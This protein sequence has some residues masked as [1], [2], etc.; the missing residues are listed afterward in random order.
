M[1]PKLAAILLFISAS[2]F[3]GW[4]DPSGRNERNLSK[5]DLEKGF[6]NPPPQAR[7]FT[8]WIWMNGNV[9]REGITADLEAM[10]RVGIGGVLL[11]NVAGSHGTDIPAGPIDYL[12][13]AWL[14]LV[15]HTASEA[16]RLGMEMG[17]H[18]CAGWATTGGPWIKPEYG[19]QQMVTAE[20]SL[21]G[22]RRVVQ[23]LPHPEVFEGYYN[24]IA[25]YAFPRNMDIGYRVHQWEPKT[26]QR[27]G[28]AGR[29]PDLSPVP[30][31]S[32]I[33]AD[34]ILE[35]SQYVNEEGVLE[36]DAPPGSW[37]IL[38]MGYTAK[39]NTNHPAAE[40]GRGLEIDK[41]RRET[42]DLH[43]REGIQPVLDHLG[44]LVGKSFHIIH[45]DS[46]EAGL[47]HWTPGMK[48]EF[49]K[50][51]GYDPTPYLLA[52]TGRL[53]EDPETTERFLWDF[54]ITISDL[55]TENYYGYLA[56]L[57]HKS[58]LH[59]LTEPYTS[60]YEG[61]R[62]AAK[63]DY[64]TAE[65][66]VNGGY[67][68]SLRH[69]ASLAHIHGRRYA[70][71]EAFT[72]APHLARW[73]NHPGSIKKVGDWAWTQ[74]IN[75]FVLHSYP[76]QP[77]I[78]VV[79]GM[80]MGQYGCHFDRNNTW[81]E[82]GRAW[83]KYLQRSQYLLQEGE[84]VADILCYAGDAAP[85]GGVI[86]PDI[87]DSGYDYDACGTD[88][89]AELKVDHGD[90]VLPSGKR[91]RLLVLPETEFMRPRFA[92][93]V[94]ELV[95]AGA[96]VLGPKP[97]YTP[98]L[99]GFPESEE[100]VMAIGE[101]VWG[102]CDGSNVTSNRFGKGQVFSGI[103]PAG[104]LK[105][106]QI[107]PQIKFP[108]HDPE[109]AWIQRHMENTDLYFLSNQSDRVIHTEAAFRSLGTK[110]EFWDAVQGQ[111]RDVHGWTVEGEHTRVPLDLMPGESVFIV[112]RY[113][114]KPGRDPYVS[115][116][117]P[118]GNNKD[119]LWY[120][121]IETA[122]GLQLRAWENGKHIV[123]HASG[124]RKEIIISEIPDPNVLEG[125]WRVQ[126][127]EGRGAP[128][129]VQFEDLV[130]WDN[131]PDTGIRFFS[132][133]AKY[134]TLFDVPES[135]MKEDQEIWLDL[136]DV[137]VIAEVRINGKEMGPLWNKPYRVEVSEVVRSGSN[138][139]EIHVT[140]LWVNRL[141]GDE[142][143]PD[144]CEWGEGKYLTQWPEWFLKGERRPEPSRLTFTTW[145][146][147]SKEDNLV[148]SGLLG[149]V[150]LRSSKLIQLMK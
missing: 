110:P 16:G 83:V 18:N 53:I 76:Q 14:D 48:E 102:D 113:P 21:W 148:P 30:E 130:S 129:E 63:A 95:L 89:L 24:D 25:V 145:K 43:W 137:E 12:S 131:H 56:D 106:M 45:L 109:I 15:K 86:R 91:Y 121:D 23:K 82:P 51:R 19:M 141:I 143:Y 84:N 6:L 69:A 59:F 42:L 46:Y 125:S 44:P 140:N 114:G 41:L 66:W 101:E 29:Q 61:L 119:S 111:I 78:D 81:W 122:K 47:H 20:L 75:R 90:V 40:S 142:Q 104:A 5:Y 55:F 34:A 72:G 7:P 73:E 65:F 116:E 93:K 49:E 100:E 146:H 107:A 92:R 79:P 58:G 33:A 112:F 97:E 10:A 35:L 39:G 11:F 132:G 60:C 120:P 26:G 126:F 128:G 27:G 85:N 50:R 124:K 4:I 13:E 2:F 64:P 135:Y 54:R 87:Q 88:I 1:K 139:M 9:T 32:A 117:L 31:G 71:A 8:F 147:W 62:V 3:P 118:S 80:T 57:C 74:G 133:T 123:Q 36:W 105:I 144:D 138:E 96:T 94:K 99:Q 37:K 127:Q 136:G 150:T 22:N 134:S 103:S 17:L 108:A 28:R 149:P 77:W 115:V 70:S 68:F 98:S 52:L 67:S 38:R